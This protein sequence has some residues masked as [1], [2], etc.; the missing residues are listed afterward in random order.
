L[1][2]AAEDLCVKLWDL[3]KLSN[4]KTIQMEN[5]MAVNAVTFDFSGIYLA[6]AGSDLRVYNTKTFSVVKTFTDHT[7]LVTDVAFGP[8]AKFLV[9]T[10][11]DR[12]MKIYGTP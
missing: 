9:S 5:D 3:R 7:A 10:S 4:F 6:T 1:A 2:T 12:N 8:D 11:M